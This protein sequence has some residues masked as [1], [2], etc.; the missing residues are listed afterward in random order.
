MPSQTIAKTNGLVIVLNTFLWFV[1]GVRKSS[2][3]WKCQ[4]KRIQ[5][6]RL[7]KVGLK[8]HFWNV[9]KT[10]GLDAFPTHCKNGWFGGRFGNFFVFCE[11]GCTKVQM[12][13]N[14]GLNAFS[15]TDSITL[16]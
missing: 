13:G 14:V 3:V 10:Q 16:A 4:V 12:Y 2:N 8:K 1:G 11:V 5:F 6:H 7:E 9:L 15:F